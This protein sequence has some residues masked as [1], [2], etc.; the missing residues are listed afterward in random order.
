MSARAFAGRVG[1]LAGA[2][3]AYRQRPGVRSTREDLLALQR[4]RLVQTARHAAAAS[5]LYHELYG[6]IELS[7]DLELRKLPVVTKEMLMGR[8]DEWVSDPRLR[9]RE[10]QAHMERIHE[11]ERYLGEYRCLVSSGTTGHQGVFVYGRD[12]WRQLLAMVLRNSEL[13]GLPPG[14]GRRVRVATVTATSPLHITGRAGIGLDLPGY[15]I[16][17]LDAGT[18]LAELVSALNE[19]RPAYLTGYASV[20][21]LLAIEQLENRLAISPRMVATGGEVRSEEMTANIRNAWGVEPFNQYATTEGLFGSD[22]EHHQGIHVFEDLCLVEVVDEHANP[23]PEGAVGAKLLFTSFISRS[24]PILRY[25]ITDRVSLTTAPCLCGRPLARIISLE[26]RSEDLLRFEGAD[27]QRIIVHPYTL[28]S[29]MAALPELR[30]YKIV[31]DP[32][33]LHVLVRVRDGSDAQELSR[34][35]ELE[36]RQQLQ[37]AGVAAP[38]LDVTVVEEI[39]RQHGHAAKFTQIESR[40]TRSTPTY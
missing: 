30:Q 40:E 6:E 28:Q 19:H 8:F 3:R 17:R 1:D 34:R 15:P 4:R 5:V 20:L 25:E 10:V 22:C 33:G 12:D 23:V 16:R 31:N 14:A 35:I 7:N 21:S 32:T 13:V 9:L 26:G 11:D 38:R 36:L 29:T 24:Q 37:A 2:M 39:P 27:G 18:P